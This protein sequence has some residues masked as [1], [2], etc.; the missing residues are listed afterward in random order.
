MAVFICVFVSYRI[1]SLW[2]HS[3]SKLFGNVTIPSL[4]LLHRMQSEN[5]SKVNEYSGV[6][7]AEV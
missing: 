1:C 7:K 4:L 2:I 5:I 3:D 6:L